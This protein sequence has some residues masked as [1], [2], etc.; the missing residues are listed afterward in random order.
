MLAEFIDKIA[1]M[2]KE[3]FEIKEIDAKKYS[4]L[5]LIPIKES[6]YPTLTMSSL[7]GLISWLNSNPNSDQFIVTIEDNRTIIVQSKMYG[8]FKQ[9]DKYII[10]E[11]DSFA[12]STQI[13]NADLNNF[14]IF[15]QTNF[16]DTPEKANLLKAISKIKT[17]N[18]VKLSDD[19]VSQV[20]TVEQGV[21]RLTEA[22]IKPIVTLCPYVTFAE[23]QQPG[24]KYLFRINNSNDFPSFSLHEVNDALWLYKIKNDIKNYLEKHNVDSLILV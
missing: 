24:C 10:C 20:V 5:D 21:K 3:R 19:G 1:Y 22:E 2:A 18:G 6:K 11:C 13:S 17:D 23:I 7:D 14:I 4:Y 15:L 8:E 16:V 12:K 9:R